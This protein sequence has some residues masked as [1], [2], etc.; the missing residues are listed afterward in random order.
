MSEK[1]AYLLYARKQLE[2]Y[3]LKLD[4]LRARALR[5]GDD[6]RMDYHIRLGELRSQLAAIQSGV[7]DLES[8]EDESWLQLKR[9]VDNASRELRSTFS[10]AVHW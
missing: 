3:R 4:E 8:R 10:D 5:A 7:Q 1:Q 6:L 9:A 2:A